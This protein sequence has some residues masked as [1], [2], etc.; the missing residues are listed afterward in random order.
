MIAALKSE[1]RKLFTIRSTYIMC[2]VALL[3]IA[4]FSFYF[5]GFKGNT[6]SP[7]AKLAPTAIQEMVANSSGMIAT[8]ISIITILMMAHEYR[9]NII[10]H[11]LTA[12]RRR[13]TVL[14]AKIIAAATFAFVVGFVGVGFSLLCY[15]LG[16]SLRDASLP[17][18]TFGAASQLGRLAVYFVAYALV[19]V[20]L[21]TLIRSVVGAIAFFF[22]VPVTIEPLL[23]LVLKEKAVY[24]PFAALDNITGASMIQH[25]ISHERAMLVA[26]IYLLIGWLIAW[27]LF[28]RRDAN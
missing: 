17:A 3:L 13:T 1:F 5:E 12:A 15:Y 20:L 27:Y 11:T 7:A 10:M 23:S 16:L 25:P 9:Y 26:L 2:I 4:L 22:I 24:L 19:G 14:L 21:A 8:F 6:G 18:Q 28:L